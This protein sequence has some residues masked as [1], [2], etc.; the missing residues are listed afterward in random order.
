MEH[1]YL[2][3][4]LILH[5]LCMV[6][7]HSFFYLIGLNNPIIFVITLFEII[8]LIADLLYHLVQ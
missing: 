4:R 8:S 6:L 1:N 2:L 7:F 5:L 3:K